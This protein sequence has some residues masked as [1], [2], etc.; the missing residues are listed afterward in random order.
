MEEVT[1]KKIKFSDNE[2]IYETANIE[3]IPQL[4]THMR[5]NLIKIM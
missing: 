1:C 5:E 4:T 2:T 3:E